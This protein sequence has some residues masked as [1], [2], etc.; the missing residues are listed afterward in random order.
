M[1]SDVR[2]EMTRSG[3]V[4]EFFTGKEYQ[5]A[6]IIVVG[7]YKENLQLQSNLETLR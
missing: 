5:K 6:I 4:K 1:R 3:T 7:K 2:K